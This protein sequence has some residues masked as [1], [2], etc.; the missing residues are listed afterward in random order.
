[1][2]RPWLRPAILLVVLLALMA[3]RWDKEA[4]KTYDN[5]VATW[6]RDRWTQRTWRNT[7]GTTA[8]DTLVEEGPIPMLLL[9][10]FP[11]GR[12]VPAQRYARRERSILTG[13]WAT[14]MVGCIFWLVG[15]LKNPPIRTQSTTEQLS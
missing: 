12:S 2:H 7:Y 1:M 14:G 13:L 10:E 3:F 8:K 4:Q 6:T 5:G 11:T 15:S 9:G